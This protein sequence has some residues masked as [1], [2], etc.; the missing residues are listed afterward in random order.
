MFGALYVVENL[1]EYQA[2]PEQYLAA[3]PLPIKDGLLKF[4]SRNTDWK[5]D[6]LIAAVNPI[7]HG[8]SYE[9]GKKLFTVANCVACH[10]VKGEGKEIGPDL[11]KIDPKR[12]NTEHLLRSLVEPSKDIE[13]KYQSYTF[14]LLNGK[15]ATGMIVEEDDKVVKL[16]VDPLAKAAPRVIKKS[17]I[18]E[19]IKSKKSIMP[20][21]LASKLTQEEIVDLLAYIFAKGEEKHMLFHKHNH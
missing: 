7:S 11:A 16:L 10:K 14:V 12:F 1:E 8:R 20:E 17:N 9:V 19:R 13:E 3:N 6:D 21:G 2:N 18:D 4:I 15:S 5:F